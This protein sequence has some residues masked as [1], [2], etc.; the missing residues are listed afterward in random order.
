[1]GIDMK[2]KI[3][4]AVLLAALIAACAVILSHIVTFHDKSYEAKNVSDSPKQIAFTFDDGPGENTEMLLDGL[5]ERGAKA[6]FFLIGSKAEKN[7]ELVARIY[8]EGH[9]IG[10]HTYSHV[11]LRK[12]SRA[13]TKEQIDKTNAIIEEITGEKPAFIRPPYGAYSPLM[14]ERI[15]EIPIL[16]SMCP[17]DWEHG[18]DEDYICNYIVEHAKDGQIVLLHDPRPAT[19]PAVLRAMDILK[20]E[21]YEF[22]RA[23]EL[24]CRGGAKLSAGLAYRYCGNNGI[25]FWF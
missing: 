15:D 16:W 25:I 5:H 6:S 21:G 7:P 24:L 22:V 8:G 13:E 20:E 12:A 9:L 1:M 19:V 14:L 18:D 23:D 10:N 3:L 11:N 2:K 17:K 4:K